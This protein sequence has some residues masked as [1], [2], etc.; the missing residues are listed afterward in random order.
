MKL[1]VTELGIS[2]DGKDIEKG[3][4]LTV[5][6]K[7]IPP[8]LVNKA[9]EVEGGQVDEP[10]KDEGD[11]KS[12]AEVLAL[13]DGNFMAFKSAARKLLGDNTPAS[14]GEI[15]SS[16]I[17]L[18]TDSELKTFL[19]AK[20]VQTTDETRD[21]SLTWQRP[22]KR[23]TKEANCHGKSDW[24]LRLHW[25]VRRAHRRPGGHLHFRRRFGDGGYSALGGWPELDNGGVDHRR[26]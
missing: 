17:D 8:S 24:N 22:R 21:H 20:G 1:K 9:V 14:K 18:L 19:A 5:A 12:P 11:R 2:Q 4:I 6:G 25:A 7:V 13:A 23:P 10:K 26:R 16:L 3:E 15:T